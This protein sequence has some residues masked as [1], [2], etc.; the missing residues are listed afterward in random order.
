MGRSSPLRTSLWW[1]LRTTA[2][3]SRRT[4]FSRVSD[5]R[6]GQPTILRTINRYSD[7]IGW[8]E[9]RLTPEQENRTTIILDAWN[10]M[11]CSAAEKHGFACIDIYHAFNGQDGSNPAGDLLAM[12]YTHPSDKGNV[13]IAELLASQGFAPLA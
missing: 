6:K 2:P 11:L 3:S 10:E 7:W 9:A 12:D 1:A 13:L 4:L 5:L 8:R